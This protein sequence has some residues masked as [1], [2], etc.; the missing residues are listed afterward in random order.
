MLEVIRPSEA[1]NGDAAPQLINAAVTYSVLRLLR[2]FYSHYESVQVCIFVC[3]YACLH[4]S[5]LSRNHTLQLEVTLLDFWPVGI[6]LWFV[7]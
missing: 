1:L 3:L 6:L 7:E 2:P 5:R 4:E